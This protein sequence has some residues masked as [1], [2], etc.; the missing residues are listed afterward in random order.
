MLPSNPFLQLVPNRANAALR[1]L[2]DQ[3]WTRLGTVQVESAP[4]GIDH[5]SL[6]VARRL[7]RRVLPSGTAWGRLYDQRWSRLEVKHLK[8]ESPEGDYPITAS[9]ASALNYEISYVAGIL[10]V[11]PAAAQGTHYIATGSQGELVA[12]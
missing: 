7:P 3:I 4:P 5:V 1:R 9:G 10:K 12:G 2:Q 8:I 11:G 6:A